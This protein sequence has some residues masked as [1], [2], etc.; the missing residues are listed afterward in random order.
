MEILAALLFSGLV[1][2]VLGYH[3]H[4]ALWSG[5]LNSWK[6]TS[7]TWREMYFDLKERML[8]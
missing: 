2:F 3:A 1:G 5:I 7:Q 6:R 8:K 4:A